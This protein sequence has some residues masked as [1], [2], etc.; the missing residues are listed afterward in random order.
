MSDTQPK[1]KN[2][3]NQ[4]FTIKN[5]IE[6]NQIALKGVKSKTE[7]HRAKDFTNQCVSLGQAPLSHSSRTSIGRVE[8]SGTPLR[9]ANSTML[10]TR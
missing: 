9:V 6:P 3:K 5:G 7:M 10:E 4:K 1:K 8:D 2:Q